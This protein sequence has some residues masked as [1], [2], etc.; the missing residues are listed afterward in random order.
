METTDTLGVRVEC[1]AGY[2]G[3]ERPVRFFLNKRCIEITEILDQWIGPDYRY[4]KLRGDDDGIYVLRH[5]SD[6]NTWD[7][8]LF[9]S[10]KREETRLSST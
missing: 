8:T 7:L 6:E 2:R 5:L 9:D 10:G 3:E 4:F 1:Y